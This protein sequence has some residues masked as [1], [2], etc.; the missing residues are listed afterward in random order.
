MVTALHFRIL[1]P[2]EAERDGELLALGGMRQRAVLACLLISAGRVVPADRLIDDV[3]D[4]KPPAAAQA[5]LQ[6]YISNL[7]KALDPGR[8]KGAA[9]ALLPN[10]AGGY[11]LEAEADAVDARRFERLSHEG[12]RMLASGEALEAREALGEALAL[13]RGPALVDFS[14][15]SFAQSEEARLDEIRMSAIED[16]IDADISL[17]RHAEV[18]A[19]AEALASSH[20]LRERLWGQL[21]L[22]LYRSGRQAGALEVYERARSMLVAELGID[23]SPELREL[24]AAILRHDGWLAGDSAGRRLPAQHSPAAAH[25]EFWEIDGPRLVALDGDRL[26]VGKAASNDIAV[27][28]DPTVSRLHAVLERYTS[29]WAL[30]DLASRNGTF[31]NGERVVAERALRTGDEIMVGSTRIVF[32][33]EEAA[34]A[35]Q[36]LGHIGPPALSP[37]ERRVLLA[38]CRPVLS[39]HA[40][41]QPASIGQIGAEV[42]LEEAVVEQHVRDLCGKFG[43]AAE[44]DPRARLANEAIR[45]RA[46]TAHEA[47]TGSAN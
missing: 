1:G 19:E 35:T 18:A 26:T 36:T 27:P 31:V 22:A 46:V 30:R 9:P 34:D 28:S 8:P 12:R 16:R 44:D 37:A 47:E 23:P 13:W 32:R 38:L 42:A 43:I 14:Y 2:L 21:M 29:G 7:R 11:V 39:G 24:Q 10:R 15:A 20:P 17:G 45:R 3:W 6:G 5:T 40:F 4:G 41:T 25:L 33:L